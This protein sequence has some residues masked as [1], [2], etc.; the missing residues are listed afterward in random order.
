MTEVAPVGIPVHRGWHLTALCILLLGAAGNAWP[1]F[2]LDRM[3]PGDFP[4]YVA[5]VQYVR[6]ALLAHGRVPNWC[7]PCLGG[8]SQ[9]TSN[10]KEYLAFPL[11]VALDPVLATKLAYLVLRVLGGLGLYWLAVRRFAAPLAGIV[12][13][14]AASFGAIPNHHL[15]LDLALASALLPPIVVAAVEVIGGGSAVWVVVLGT[16]AAALLVNNWVYALP[17]PI[18]IAGMMLARLLGPGS[19]ASATTPWR[20]ALVARMAAALGVAL[21]LAASTIG[22]L[23]AD[24]RHHALLHPTV[25]ERARLDYIQ[26]SPFLLVNREDVLA[27]W[28]TRHQPPGLD[29]TVWDKDTSYVGIAVLGSCLIAWPVLRRRRELLCW[30]R[31]G[32]GMSL[33]V[34]WLSLGERTMLWQ[35]AWSFD[36]NPTGLTWLRNALV[37][38]SALCVVGAGAAQIARRARPAAWLARQRASRLLWISIALLMPAVPLWS[39][40]AAVLPPFQVQR[41]PGH[42]FETLPFWLAIAFAA[43]LAALGRAISRPRRAR[44]VVAAIGTAMV[45]DFAPTART[46]AAGDPMEKLESAAA[47]LRDLDGEGGTIRLAIPQNLDPQVSWILAQ[48]RV[49]QARNWLAWQA[50]EQW[51]R[52]FRQATRGYERAVVTTPRVELMELARVRYFLAPRRKV[53][54]PPWRPREGWDDLDLSELAEGNLRLWELPAVDPVALAYRSYTRLE[55]DPKGRVAERITLEKLTN[56]LLVTAPRGS[57]DAPRRDPPGTPP[58]PVAYHRPS[59]EHIALDVDAG[60]EPALIFVSE[61]HHPW[62]RVAI[63]G[64]PGTLLR[65]NLTFIAVPVAAGAHRIDLRF[66]PPLWLRFVDRT[67]QL[68]CAA[69]VLATPVFV[70]RARRG[71]RRRSAYRT[72]DIT[73]TRVS[74]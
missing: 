7:V 62:W 65:A 63:D 26:R 28:L 24:S 72:R 37:A 71:A 59:P 42:F 9:F 51:N 6:D 10:L 69:L 18:A 57:W 48:A 38:A 27:S 17:V 41:S 13:G 74:S 8:A 4:G 73:T 35:L 70:W 20:R 60:Q 23:A 47:K 39:L 36:V 29:I 33:F 25:I 52:F 67:S 68:A 45:L 50:G 30:A 21:M 11:A 61:S 44:A 66:V 40:L 19:E 64:Q 58:F 14:Y 49:G 15:L 16:L 34:Y 12:A 3:P 1:W 46:F 5:Q 22:W 2:A 55:V 31:L 32:L 54:Q 53:L 56:S 43:S